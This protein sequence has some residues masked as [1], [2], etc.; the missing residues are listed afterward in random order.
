VNRSRTKSALHA[1]HRHRMTEAGA[2]RIKDKNGDMIDLII[3][4]FS[5]SH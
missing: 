5:T 1:P 4:S 2:R 3:S